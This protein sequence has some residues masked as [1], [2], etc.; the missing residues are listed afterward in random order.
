M[1]SETK[2]DLVATIREFAVPGRRFSLTS[3]QQLAGWITG[4]SMFTPDCD[5]A[6]AFS[7]RKW[8]ENL[9]HFRRCASARSSAGSSYGWLITWNIP[10]EYS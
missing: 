9:N 3:F 6:C 8:P 10:K 5:Q 2:A 1:P 4:P 7:M